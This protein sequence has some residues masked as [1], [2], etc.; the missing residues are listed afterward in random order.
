[1]INHTLPQKRWR[2]KNSLIKWPNEG[3]S[4]FCLPIPPAPSPPG[5]SFRPHC[6]VGWTVRSDFLIFTSRK[7]Q[8]T[9]LIHQ[10]TQSNPLMCD[11]GNT[12]PGER[13]I[14][15][16]TATTRGSQFQQPAATMPGGGKFLENV[17]QNTIP[18]SPS[19]S[20]VDQW[21]LVRWTEN[22]NARRGHGIVSEFLMFPFFLSLLG[23]EENSPSN[24]GHRVVPTSNGRGALRGKGN[25]EG[26]IKN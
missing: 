7:A 13:E 11:S 10:S 23:L 19:P 25:S 3:V 16:L 24:N 20:P 26:T 12:A 21:W 18:P 22:E 14:F 4:P 2:L 1:M 17:Y 6:R 15:I 9:Y 8:L 5:P